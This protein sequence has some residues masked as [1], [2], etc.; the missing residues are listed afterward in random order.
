MSKNTWRCGL[1]DPSPTPYEPQDLKESGNKAYQAK[2]F[3]GAIELYTQ[4]TKRSGAML[5]CLSMARHLCPQLSHWTR[6][7][8]LFTTIALLRMCSLAPSR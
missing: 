6:R 1:L 7:A 8:P 4:G 3:R 5:A 2:D